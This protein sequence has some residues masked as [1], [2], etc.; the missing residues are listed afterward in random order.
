MSRLV[1]DPKLEPTIGVA[2]AAEIVGISRRSGYGAVYRGEWPT[3]RVGNTYRVNTAKFLAQYGL[4]PSRE[5]E[6]LTAA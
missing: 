4:E 3:I 1:P 6:P 2:R 5:T